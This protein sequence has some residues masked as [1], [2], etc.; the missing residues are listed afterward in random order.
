MDQ[1]SAKRAVQV[2]P[3]RNAGAVHDTSGATNSPTLLQPGVRPLPE[4][5]RTKFRDQIHQ[6]MES[7]GLGRASQLHDVPDGIEEEHGQIY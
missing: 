3:H 7:L 5:H 4:A 2:D 1:E 6:P